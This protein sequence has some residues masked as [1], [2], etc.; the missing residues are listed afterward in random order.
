MKQIVLCRGC[1]V[2]IVINVFKS[3]F[4]VEVLKFKEVFFDIVLLSHLIN[5]FLLWFFW[6]LLLAF[7]FFYKNFSQMDCFHS[8]TTT[9]NFPSQIIRFK[10][11]TNNLYDSEIFVICN[12]IVCL[13]NYH[14]SDILKVDCIFFDKS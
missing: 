10:K 6:V 1:A 4:K 11:S 8:S 7:Q 9:N 13:I 3:D 2:K 5:H 14:K 12:C